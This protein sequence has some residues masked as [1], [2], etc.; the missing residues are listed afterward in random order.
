MSFL[1]ENIHHILIISTPVYVLA[2][3]LIIGK[4]ITPIQY[5]QIIYYG[6]ISRWQ[7]IC[8][9]IIMSGSYDE[10]A[11]PIPFKL[12]SVI[13]YPFL[14][15]VKFVAK[16][17]NPHMTNMILL[18]SVFLGLHRWHP[19]RFW[20]VSQ[21]PS[22]RPLWLCANWLSDI[23]LISFPLACSFFGFLLSFCNSLFVC[24]I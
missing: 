24:W 18:T 5:L 14:L 21:L 2:H 20:M 23:P 9:C 15:C 10:A 16:C 12:L 6:I 1:Q 22:G 8:S 13:G 19:T 7:T 17:P 4:Q 3:S 11:V